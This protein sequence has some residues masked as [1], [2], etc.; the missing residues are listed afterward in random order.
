MVRVFHMRDYAAKAISMARGHTRSDLDT[1]EK[2]RYALT[3]LV[4]LVGEAASQASPEIRAR[5]PEIPWRQ[6]IGMRHRLIHGY[7]AVDLDILWD[8]ISRNL[9][10]LL[11][12]L[13]RIL[14]KDT[15]KPDRSRGE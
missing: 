3:H 15:S 14:A 12:I 9:P 6:A 10:F 8:T 11:Y 13:E 2:L 7:D 5:F 4:E 1:D